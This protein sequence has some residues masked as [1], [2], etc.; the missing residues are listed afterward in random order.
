MLKYYVLPS[1]MLACASLAA[2]SDP[3]AV[4]EDNFRAAIEPTVKDAFCRQVGL[5]RYRLTEKAVN[6]LS[7]FPLVI[8]A[9]P[10]QWSGSSETAM[11]TMLDAAANEGLLTRTAKTELAATEFSSDPLKPT[12]VLVF[13]PTSKGKNVFRGV[14]GKR[15]GAEQ[16]NVCLGD[17]KVDQI[18]RWTEP[19]DAFGQTM[20]QVTYTYSATNLADDLPKEM[21]E[22]ASKPREAKVTLVKMSDGWQV[23]K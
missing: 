1:V 2:C 22:Q 11:R 19:G 6:D 7:A 14:G 13:E 4:S 23:M 20:T 18:V 3:K 12:P 5:P 10:S 16:P 21:I 17:G 9:T 15:G 8:A